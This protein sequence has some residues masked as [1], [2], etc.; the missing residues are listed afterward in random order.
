[1][2]W[3]RVMA[4]SG[5]SLGCRVPGRRSI[6]ELER[7]GLEDR[8]VGM[9]A[10]IELLETGDLLLAEE[11][12]QALGEIGAH[13][14]GVQAELG[15]RFAHQVVE[16][17]QP[18]AQAALEVKGEVGKLHSGAHRPYREGE[19]QPGQGVP[20]G[21]QIMD[22]VA[23][24]VHPQR[25]IADQQRGVGL[26]QHPLRIR[27]LVTVLGLDVEALAHQDAQQRGG[28]PAVLV[29]RHLADLA[30]RAAR[31]HQH[32]AHL[33]V[34]GDAQIGQHLEARDPLHLDG[35]DQTDVEIA[36][37]EQ[38]GHQRRRMVAGREEIRMVPLEEAPG[39]RLAV[40]E[41]DDADAQLGQGLP[42]LDIALRNSWLL[43]AFDSLSC[44]SSMLSTVD[45]GL[46]TLRS[47]QT[48]CSSP[49]GI[50]SSSLRVPDLLM[51][52]A[53]K[54]RLSTS[55][56]SRWISEL[57][58]PLNSSKM[59]SSM[60]LPVSTRA[61]ATMVSE[62][63]S[64]MLRAAPKKRFGRCS[65]FE[66]TPPESTLP[67]GGTMVLYARARR[68]IES[69]RITTSFLCSTSR[70]AFSITISATC[71]WR[72]AG[73]SNVLDTTSPFTVRCISVTSSGRSSM[74]STIS[75]TSG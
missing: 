15:G 55:L 43:L 58:V 17:G 30:R 20:F 75:E 59:T 35:R 57:P 72:A 26:R 13:L 71:T 64:S 16:R 10:A 74:S 23:L 70:L 40:E 45:S 66:S 28:G 46:S 6:P 7:L 50:S 19:R 12:V 73:S 32:A 39:Q 5:S 25:G 42:Y 24:A 41:V 38:P 1:M 33:V 60:R 29:E 52:I 44:S 68:V 62:P 4:S 53:G 67:E 11:E 21:G 27:A 49:S 54:T 48:R 36:L 8:A 9:G 69:S 31:D 14:G 61:V 65:A 2:G 34:C 56:R 18:V 37:A 22:P 47:T 3:R 63:P 51:S